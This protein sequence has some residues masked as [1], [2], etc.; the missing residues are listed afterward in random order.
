MCSGQIAP[1]TLFD[2]FKLFD[3]CSE[4]EESS[5]LQGCKALC[6]DRA[7]VWTS[8]SLSNVVDAFIPRLTLKISNGQK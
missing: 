7:S 3:E 4:F 1:L 5:G 6:I 8:A 2:I